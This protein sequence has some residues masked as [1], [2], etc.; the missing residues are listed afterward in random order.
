MDYILDIIKRQRQYFSS[1][2]MRDYKE[3]KKSLLKLRKNIL[4][5]KDEIFEALRMDLGKGECESYMTEV[6]LS[7]SEIRFMLKHGKS[8]S[9]KRRVFL[10]LSE[11][12]SKGYKIPTPYGSVL[13]ISPWNYPFMLSIEPIIDAVIAGNSVIL[14]PSEISPNVS[15]V[16]TKLIEK[17]FE[18]G[19]VDVVNGG[20]E[21]CT[22]LLDQDFDYIFYTGSTR[23]G[24]IVMQKASE[25]FTPVTLE[26]GGKCPCIVDGSAD[27][28]LSARRIVFGKFLN[29]GQTCVAPDYIYCHESVKDKLIKYLIEEI[30]L[31]YKDALKNENYPKLV[32]EKQFNVMKGFIDGGDVIYGGNSSKE[33][34]KIEPTLIFSTFESETMQDEIFGPILPI[35]TFKSEDEAIKNINSYPKPLALYIFSQDKKVQ[36]KFLDDCDSG[37]G[38][39]ND[40]IMHIADSKLGFGGIKQ[41]GMGSYHGKA[42]FDTFTHY[43]SITKKGKFDLPF[44]YQPF[45]K[46]KYKIIKLFL[47]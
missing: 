21:E 6:G 30:K 23:V 4:E 12:P 41:S 44:R 5:M 10:S 1:G 24:K 33:N 45:N 9:K 25:H 28:K 13:I 43:K 40:T 35:V 8:Y 34:L 39:I 37:G 46:L 3:R 15:K 32:S 36:Q 14:K 19:H 47:K 29:S 26:L 22:F 20:K 27:L 31:Q 17:S 11:F 16:I 2:K 7:L 42:G 18:R 38:C